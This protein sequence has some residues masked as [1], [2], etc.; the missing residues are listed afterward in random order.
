MCVYIYMYMY[1]QWKI[2]VILPYFLYTWD[3][4]IPE[5]MSEPMG[6]ASASAAMSRRHQTYGAETGGLYMFK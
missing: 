5:V 2:P 6:M 3:I 4:A 1:I